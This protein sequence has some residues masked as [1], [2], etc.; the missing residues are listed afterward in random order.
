M[1]NPTPQVNRK[2]LWT[3][4]IVAPL[5]VYALSRNSDDR[6]AEPVQTPPADAALDTAVS[7]EPPNGESKAAFQLY[8][9]KPGT[10]QKRSIT[11]EQ[12]DEPDTARTLFVSAQELPMLDIRIVFDGGGARDGDHPGLAAMVSALIPEGTRNKDSGEIAAT[13][14]SVGASFNAG[15]YRDMATLELRT[16]V[17]PDLMNPALAMLSELV[18]E[19]SFPPEALERE[20]KRMLAGLQ[21]KRQNPSSLASDR[22]Y[23]E[24]YGEHPYAQPSDGTL[25]SVPGLSREQI[26]DFFRTYYNRNNALIAMVGAIDSEQAR[27]IAAQIS[28]ALLPGEPAPTPPAPVPHESSL[29]ARV[30]FPSAQA[31]LLIGTLGV[32]RTSENLLALQLANEV[33]GGGGLV[34]V[35]SQ[36]IREKR[37]MAYSAY[38]YFSPMRVPGPFTLGLQT[39]SDQA[40]EALAVA[41]ET[42]RAFAESGP[43]EEQFERAKQH[44]LGSFPLQTSSNRSIVGYLGAIGFYGLPLDYLETYTQRLEKIDL[45]QATKAFQEVID[46]DRL[47]IVHVG[48]GS[49]TGTDPR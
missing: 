13:F 9:P 42:L 4:L 16:L 26:I 1:S 46:P 32:S 6:G 19:A 36:E 39:R 14:E 29:K 7:A 10:T 8:S 35:L 21:Q 37:G 22:F 25:E 2:V 49:E 20:R 30:E 31:H 44:M 43:T 3:L 15:S 24:L 5:L 23:A 38:S 12:I 33:L 40:G 34:S 48:P 41:R 45:K 28:A 18:R 11:I 47:L 27:T 17:K